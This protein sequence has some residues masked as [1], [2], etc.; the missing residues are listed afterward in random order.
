MADINSIDDLINLSDEELSRVSIE[1]L[2]GKVDT[3]EEENGDIDDVT[4][5]SE[6]EQTDSESE[7]EEESETDAEVDENEESEETDDENSE[8]EP[9]EA[10]EDSN[11]EEE[12][13]S[14]TSTPEEELVNKILKNPIRANNRDITVKDADEAVRL[15]QMGL[16]MQEKTKKLKPHMRLIKTLE[17]AQLLDENK[18]NY[19][20]DLL[21]GDKNAIMKL[22]KDSKLD[23]LD[24][25]DD[26]NPDSDYVPNNHSVTESR[27]QFD[28][29]LES[30]ADSPHKDETL[31]YIRGLDDQSFNEVRKDPRIITAIN[32]LMN[33]GHHSRIQGELDKA[34]LLGDPL[35][36]GKS[37]LEAYL[38]VAANL[39]KQGAFSKDP[40][41]V[42]QSSTS[43]SK[44]TRNGKKA[45]TKQKKA[46]TTNPG[47]SGGAS[48]KKP[49]LSEEDFMNM[50]DEEFLKHL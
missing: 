37:D 13:E 40:A 35:V 11:E 41:P 20:I 38:L 18:I 14:E 43:K 6:E 30:I 10:E 33:E 27:M 23:P 9:D 1:S 24:L 16:G 7:V 32:N 5:P 48:V 29:Q 46:A 49:T 8:E 45:D 15:I 25:G 4:P 50:S 36:S 3:T 22:V 42:N 21:N 17:N 34:Q 26:N 12:T 2:E 19:A 47:N 39:D 31:T 44:S 28:E